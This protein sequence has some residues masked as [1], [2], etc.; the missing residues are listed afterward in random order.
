VR[1]RKFLLA[2]SS[3][4]LG[5]PFGAFAQRASIPFIGFLNTGSPNERK[6]LVDAFRQGLKEGGYADGKDVAIEYRWAEGNYER[7]PDLARDL[8]ER[9]VAVI[10]ATGGN[11]PALA[12]K[13]ATSTIPIVFTGGTDPVK[14]GLVASL[15]RPG[16]NV[17]GVA[18]ISAS[19]QAKR[20]QILGEIVPGAAKIVYLVNP[21]GALADGF[22]KEIETA[23][24][25][26][27]TKIEVLSASNESEIDA[28]FAAMKKIHANAL[29]VAA[30]PF[31][32]SRRDQIV[33]LAARH[34]IPACY[35]FREYA[36]AGGLMSYG[37]DIADGYRQAGVYAARILKGAK[38]ADLPVIQL[39]K[40]Q[41][42]VNLKTARKVGLVISRDFLARI[43]EVIE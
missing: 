43:D 15:S 12:A 34:R 18:N 39:T 11:L 29:L 27:G 14:L 23:A 25:A 17:T 3:A 35:S 36:A 33:A 2:F 28:G 19:L 42:I 41:L 37:A 13:S 22:V 31:F 40:F 10:V 1:R 6:H 38:P 16:G 9:K 4:T 32:L 5:W 21:K 8:V 20:L 7:L 26:I 30:D 24:E